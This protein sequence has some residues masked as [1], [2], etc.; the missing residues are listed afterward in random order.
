M[1]LVK[2]LPRALVMLTVA[3]ALLAGLGSGLA[4]LGWQT[5]NVSQNWMMI[6]GPLMI[7][8]FLGTLICMER[9]VALA[10]RYRWSILVPAVNALGGIALLVAPDAL[11]GKLLLTG[12]S[13]G[14]VLLFGLML[15]L[16]PSHDM[17]IM[18]AAALCWLAGNRLW[19]AGVPVYQV[20][21]LWT[22]FLIL[23][24][25][26]ERLELSRVR[27]LSTTSVRLLTLTIV[28]YL[29]GTAWTPFNLDAGLRLLGVGVVLMAGWLLRYDVARRTIRKNGLPR[30][31]AACL[32]AGYMWLGFGGLMAIWQGAVFAG[33]DYSVVLHAFLLGFVFSMIFGHAPI[34]L[35]ALTG[36]Q[37]KYTPLF[38]GHLILLHVTL[39]YRTYGNLAGSMTVRQHAG[40]LNVMVVLLFLVVTVV[41]V[42]RSHVAHVRG[43]NRSLQPEATGRT[44]TSS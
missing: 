7:S 41:T 35:P 14:L 6:H 33:P 39:A 25:V 4:R 17:V 44:Q 12:G 31:I 27:R 24:I 16:H 19:L 10:S 21:H 32:L 20:V 43:A 42:W 13:L 28:V 18:T 40:L 30:Y 15:R 2:H 3:V 37:M 8:G 23:T 22:A 38:Y 34:I 1:K 11:L 36:L 26:G 9:A 29:A 5:D